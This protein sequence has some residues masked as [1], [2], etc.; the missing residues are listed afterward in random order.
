MYQSAYR[1]Y[2]SIKTALLRIQN[3]LLLGIEKQKV[4]ALALL[5]LS[6]AFDTVDHAVLIDRLESFFGLSGI[7]LS[8]VKSYLTDRTQSVKIGEHLSPPVLLNTGIP[9]GSILG[10]LLFSMY[11]APLEQT[12]L[13]EG[14]S[15]H[16][17]A[18]DTQIYMSFSA[19]DAEHS[20]NRLTQ[21]LDLV[22][23]WFTF[24]KLSLNPD[25][26]EYML[27]GTWQQHKKLEDKNLS[28]SFGGHNIEPSDKFRNLG[29]FMDK[30]LI[31]KSHVSK[32]CQISYYHIRNF[33]RIRDH[34]DLNSAKLLAN[35]LVSSRLDYCNSL[36]YGINEGLSK[37]LQTVQ[38]SLARVVVP[39]VKR[40][41]H[42]SP[43][44][45]QLHLLKLASA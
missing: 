5:D 17:Y 21:V 43:V 40:T 41:D 28:F 18:D 30:H 45:K 38:N 39:S 37:K 2:H 15:F 11:T 7:A 25:K 13:S 23:T 27:I 6:A 31:L 24:N 36:L 10:P 35:A 9:Q 26:T 8:L 20:I 14:V 29:F 12:L 1:M 4:S 16:F 42:I 44:L 19:Q 32:I 33:R 3:D 22:Q 34:L